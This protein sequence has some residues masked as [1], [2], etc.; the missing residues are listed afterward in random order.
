MIRTIG[1]KTKSVIL[2]RNRVLT[3]KQV[4]FIIL[5]RYANEQSFSQKFYKS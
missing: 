4:R 1:Q 2:R 3:S 5:N